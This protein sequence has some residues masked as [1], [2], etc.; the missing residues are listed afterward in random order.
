MAVPRPDCPLYTEEPALLE[1]A[2]VKVLA[3]R[4]AGFCWGV[5]RAVEQ[6]RQIAKTGPLPVRTDGRLIHNAPMMA[7]LAKEGIE[8]TDDPSGLKGGT[9]LIRAHG[10]SPERREALRMLP[11]K[12]VD[13]TCPDVARIQ[14]TIRKY[15]GKGY[16]V[17][18][19][20][21]VGHAEV[22]GL[23]GFASNGGWVVSDPAEVAAL[24]DMDP[25]CLVSQ[26]TQLPASY[27]AVAA[28]VRARFPGAV[29][30]DT[31]CES[32]RNRQ[33]ELVE[34]AARADAIVVVGDPSSANTRRLAELA[35]SMLPTFAVQSAAELD[36]AAIRRYK[37]VA[38]TAGA[39]TPDF[40]LNAVRAALE[41]MD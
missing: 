26:S 30:L 21:D 13:A 10:I 20:G 41:A 31:I 15:A 37:V 23:L 33:K 12:L 29:I 2:P 5:R 6:A 27:D 28:A 16:A 8:E 18:V 19:F 7:A 11:L 32:T 14:G 1:S 39:S 4:S 38:L 22:L 24:P 35:R 34:L 36:P 3:A 40:V 9:L 17:I 25:V